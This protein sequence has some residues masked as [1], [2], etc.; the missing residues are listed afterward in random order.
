MAVQ[1]HGVGLVVSVV[2]RLSVVDT[3]QPVARRQAVIPSQ[4]AVGAVAAEVASEVTVAVAGVVAAVTEVARRKAL[5]LQAV[6]VTPRRMNPRAGAG[7]RRG[8]RTGWAMER[9][10]STL[11]I[12]P[13]QH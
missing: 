9:L 5:R 12:V 3:S 1:V 4:A 11:S 7:R 8:R 10:A 13:W 6:A 2:V